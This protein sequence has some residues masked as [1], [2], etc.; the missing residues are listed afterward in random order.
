M[1]RLTWQKHYLFPKDLSHAHYNGYS[2]LWSKTPKGRFM[3]GGAKYEVSPSPYEGDRDEIARLNNR[4][5]M[6][7]AVS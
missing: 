5:K 1:G 2:I 3:L 6:F 4:A 7:E